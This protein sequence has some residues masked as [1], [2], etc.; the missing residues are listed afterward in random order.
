[1]PISISFF[2]SQLNSWDDCV[3]AE[4]N[5]TF[6]YS[7][8]L[9]ESSP[10]PACYHSVHQSFLLRSVMTGVLLKVKIHEVYKTYPKCW[11]LQF[12][13]FS[14]ASNLPLL[15]FFLYELVAVPSLHSGK[16]LKV[17]VEFFLGLHTQKSSVLG[18]LLH[19]HC[20]EI[21]TRDPTSFLFFH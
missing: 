4:A 10:C 15:H 21:W 11:Y 6:H 1:M 13:T 16:K 8:K 20:I 14:W 3:L 17:I 7:S 18:L 5:L 19:Y 9:L 12:L 2:L